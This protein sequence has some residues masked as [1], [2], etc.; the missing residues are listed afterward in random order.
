MIK[1]T[2]LD[3]IEIRRNRF[4][5]FKSNLFQKNESWIFLSRTY[6]NLK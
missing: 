4:G 1:L 5:K 6:V 2:V 3:F